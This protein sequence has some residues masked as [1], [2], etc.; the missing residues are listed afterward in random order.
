MEAKFLGHPISYW[1]EVQ[2]QIESERAVDFIEEIGYL[3]AKVSYYEKRIHDMSVFMLLRQENI[4]LS[5]TATNSRFMQGL[6]PH[7]ENA[8][9]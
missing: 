7:G 5:Q 1:I 4:E 6:K 3:R 8:T 2:H 9:S